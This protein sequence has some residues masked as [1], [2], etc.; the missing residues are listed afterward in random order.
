LNQRQSRWMEYMKDYEFALQYHPGKANVVADALSRKTRRRL[1]ALRCSLHKDLM[2]LGQYD[3][4]PEVGGCT[5]FLGAVTVQ[6]SW[7][8][9]I[10]AAQAE[11]S[12]IQTRKGEITQEPSDDWSVGADG[13]LRMKGRLVLPESTE[14]RKELFDE[15]HRA[16]Y[17]VHPG[18]TKMYKD[19]RRTFWGKNLRRDVA[20]YV[21]RCF[22]YQQVKA[23]HQRPAGVLQPLA[24]PEWKWSK[25]SMDFIIGLPRSRTGND[26][27]WVV[28]DRLTKSAHFIPVKTTFTT[29][30][31]ARIYIQEIV[32]LHGVADSFVS[33]RGATFTSRFWRSFQETIGTE[34]DYSSPFHPQTD[35]QTERVNQILEDIPRAYVID[36]HGSWEE[37]FSLVEFA[38]NNS[39]RSTIRMAQY[40][41]LYGRPCRTPICWAYPEDNILLGPDMVRETTEKFATIRERIL[42]AQSR[43]KSYAE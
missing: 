3:W 26:S 19:L 21:T 31:L 13:G 2:T 22:T 23:E 16:R 36:F 12:W 18:A 20:I 24:I 27:I 35:G 40:E 43:Q 17:T 28:V 33:D 7:I 37:H 29:D 32:R 34:L 6:P 15:A 11:D 25:I 14:L 8:S 10:V 30:R 1:A 39:Y 38:Y 9:R 41:A 4:R 42:A 5:V